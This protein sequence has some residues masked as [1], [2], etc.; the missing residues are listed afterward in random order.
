MPDPQ[1][2]IY[3]A[4]GVELFRN[5][6]WE[7][8]SQAAQLAQISKSIGAFPLASGSNDSALTGELAAGFYS[9]EVASPSG[10]SGTGRAELYELDASGRTTV[11]STRVFVRS[12]EG[13]Y[14]GGFVV[15]GPAY[16]RMLLR[17]V[18]PT[19][20]TLG[21][22]NALSDPVLILYSGPNTLATNDRWEEGDNPDAV[23]AAGKAVG[24]FALAPNSE[25]AALLLTLPPGAYTVEVKGNNGAEGLALFEIYDVP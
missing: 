5:N 6:G 16:K 22:A 4:T 17:A 9:L 18:G 25:D 8:G 24:A 19:L 13:A 23:A 12:G 15:T 2:T 7:T 1:L 21:A 3:S 11:L 14:I 10:Q 20:T